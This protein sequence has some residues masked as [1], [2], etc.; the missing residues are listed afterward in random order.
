VQ[1][2]RL[3]RAAGLP[4]G[5]AQ[6]LTGIRAVEAAGI[7]RRDDLYWALHAALV[8]RREQ[9]EVF[10]QA[11]RLFWRDPDLLRRAMGLMVPGMEGMQAPP[12][13]PLPRRLAEALASPGEKPPAKDEPEIEFDAAFT[14]SDRETLGAKDFEAMSGA[15]IEAARRAIAAMRLP[16]ADL[17]TRRFRADPAGPAI[18]LRR[19]LRRS[20]RAGGAGIELA[21]R[22]RRVRPPPLVVLC[23]ISGSM[24]RYSRMLLQFV[25]AVTSDR[26]RVHA[27]TFGTSLT[28]ISRQ[29]RHR[30]PD[31]ALARVGRAVRDWEG[32][33]RI[34]QCLAEFN[35]WWA[36]RVLG[37]GAVVLLIT[38]GL[39]RDDTG[40]LAAAMARLHRSARRLIW[41]NPLLRFEGYAPKSMGAR[42]MIRHVD[43]FRP[44]HSLDSLAD[45]A[46][47]L[48][49]EA[50]RQDI[51]GR[52]AA[53]QGS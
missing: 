15:E 5:P 17:P 21:R 37:Q 3:L 33:T 7:G 11:F 18:D 34:G 51:P 13:E 12:P 24:S 16:V 31:E 8:T 44:V 35:R 43:E 28:N 47:A 26:D 49:R 22:R 29:L 27:F 4:V 19:T 45:L 9:H 36:R 6:A 52:Y 38:D 30:D 42:V 32:G 1:F 2:C 39:E 50:P 25:H 23:D 40:P 48:S 10:D 20:L 53:A 46:A 14:V 41:L